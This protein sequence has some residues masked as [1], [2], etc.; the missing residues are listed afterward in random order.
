MTNNRIS[1][2]L[3]CF[4]ILFFCQS[5]CCDSVSA[6]TSQYENQMIEKIDVTLVNVP[7]DAEA[8]EAGVRARMKTKE[9]GFFS[10]VDF[11]SDLKRLVLD[12]DH[13]EPTVDLVNGKIFITLKVWP[14]PVIRTIRWEG[15]DKIQ[16]KKLQ[17]ELG[18]ALF[19]IFDRKGFNQAF[20][21]L[22]AYYIKKGFFEA[23]L[24]YAVMPDP[25]SNE[26]DIEITV[27]EGRSGRVRDIFFVNFT[28]S[29]TSEL[30]EQMVTKRF[31]IFTNWL[32]GEGTYN[33]EAVRQDEFVIL[34]YLQDKG[35][36]DASVRIEVKE[37]KKDKNIVLYIVADKGEKYRIG[38]IT[39]QGNSFIPEDELRRIFFVKE[40]DA[41]SP[42][43]IRET[44]RR[45]M[46]YYGRK[47]Y[48]DTLVDYEPR[49]EF[50]QLTYSLTFTIEEG[51]QYRIGLIKVFGNCST[52]TNVI[53]HECLLVPGESFNSGRLR[54]TEERL[55]NIGYFKNVNVYAVRSEGPCGLGDN[56]RDVHIEVEETSTGN[57]SLFMG[58]STVESIF[59]GAN[60][61]ERNFNIKG[62]RSIFSHGLR[63]LRGGGE[64]AHITATLGD[65]STSYVISWMKPYFMDTKWTIGVNLDRTT[66][67]YISK[68]YD[69]ESY[70]LM[71]NAVYQIGPF[72]REG[73]HYR[74][75]NSHVRLNTKSDL[76]LDEAAK[77]HSLT[78]AVGVS[79]VY[80]S[81]NHPQRPTRGLKSKIEGEIAGLGGE[82]N[83]V[84]LAYKNCYYYPI[85][86][87]GIFK[88]RGDVAFLQPLAWT[89]RNE[90]P[91]D[92]RL[93]L[94]GDTVIRGYR[95]YKIGPRFPNG[96]AAG[97]ISLQLCS[98]EFSYILNE[99]MDAFAFFDAGSLS[100][101][102]WHIGRIFRSVGYG[103]RLYIMGN[104]PPL[105]FGMGYP[106]NPRNRGDVKKFF[107]QVD[108]R[109]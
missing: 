14:K 35:Y 29:E 94:G 77:L 100:S 69:I 22:K 25:N 24:D 11:D 2:L 12:F 17:S 3:T 47:G 85:M 41:Y 61:T 10:Q 65:K 74:I 27:N 73:W 9:S 103:M 59:G 72:F 42:E 83:F 18:V 95:D 46:D 7:S 54:I 89:N 28:D 53:L 45:I 33:D 108:G 30:T 60:I 57:F 70:G 64:Y 26:V 52:Q 102:Q 101:R 99:R 98:A 66:T 75:K 5:I 105:T 97:G 88:L 87:R 56:F 39:V 32:T 34:N 55:R 96:A 16:T 82:V 38:N 44:A 84:S 6:Q 20:H 4:S 80:D 90:I 13:V 51:E 68:D 8:D 36:A 78:S 79:F 62:F 48:I 81:V 104:G 63:S 15:N 106:L 71:F 50:D 21:K 86:K 49:L 92:E 40:G 107:L 19:S 76:E 37:S 23:E 93:Y 67:R 43:L 91:L 1:T 31:N 58:F 109:F